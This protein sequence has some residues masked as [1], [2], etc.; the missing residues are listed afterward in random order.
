MDK[1]RDLSKPRS[2]GAS[3]LVDAAAMVVFAL[4][5]AIFLFGFTV[6]DALI[7]A[8]YAAHLATG[9]GYRFNALGAVTDGVTPLGF[10]YLLAPFAKAGALAA[11]VAA[12]WL[13][14]LAWLLGAAF[15]G[16]AVAR[17]GREV[18][19]ATRARFRWVALL[20]VGASA[21][22]A[23]WSVAGLE[24]GLATGL[25]GASLGLAALDRPRVAA[26]LVGLAAAL[27]PE[28]LPFALVIAAG[29]NDD[30]ARGRF[31]RAAIA[32]A[33]FALVVATRLA[34][35][36]R[37]IPLSVLAKPSDLEHGAVYSAA[38]ALLTG[39][40]ALLAPF[41]F[42]RLPA[43]AKWLVA[44]VIVHFAAIAA[45]GGDWM[46]LSRLAV[47]ALP[48]VALAAA[49]VACASSRVV[50]LARVAIAVA[51]ELVTFVRLGPEAARVGEARL[52]LVKEMTPILASSRVVA[53]LDIGWLGA[54]T[55]A[56][57][58]DLA[59]L[60]DPSIAVLRGGHTSK[61]IPLGLLDARK[62]DTVTLLLLEG[63]EV[64]TPWQESYFARAV[65]LRV[66]EIP[67]LGD[68][69]QVVAIGA[70]PHLRYVV[71]RRNP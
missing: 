55:D 57:I 4:I 59:G 13:G 7:P 3:P 68:D 23:A 8:R 62:V 27:R 52:A 41:A 24:T 60:T 30:A 5:P 21:P 49:Y 22:L 37:P 39:P 31:V 64:T 2:A 14:L 18:E 9:A 66:S 40:V 12:K 46:P 44:A 71:L 10:P 58:V 47:P 20:V 51:A 43:R 17:V 1:E 15:L 63:R 16:V 48:A 70:I 19:D 54:A 25:V 32:A 61:E 67:N 29:A 33:P 26:L 53:G 11:F 6:D 56:T 38:C 45:A 36:G 65:E 35:F 42:R 28:L 50:G 69:F 34:I